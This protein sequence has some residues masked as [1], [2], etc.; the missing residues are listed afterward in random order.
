LPCYESHQLVGALD[1]LSAI[2]EGALRL[3][4]VLN[5][6]RW[7]PFAWTAILAAAAALA[8]QQSG[9]GV[10]LIEFLPESVPS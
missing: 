10:R 5:L 4:G 2:V 9:K 7:I 8:G 1:V 3:A 6:F